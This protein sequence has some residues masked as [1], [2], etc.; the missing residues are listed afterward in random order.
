MEA[1]TTSNGFHPKQRTFCLIMF[2][3]HDEP[4]ENLQIFHFSFSSVDLS[5]LHGHEMIPH[6]LA[7]LLVIHIILY[8]LLC[9]Q[10]KMNA[11]F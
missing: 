10:H 9:I 8:H 2:G 4:K 11:P 6:G 3:G 7:N 1:K 5:N